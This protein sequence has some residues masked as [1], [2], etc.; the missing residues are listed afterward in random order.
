MQKITLNFNKHDPNEIDWRQRVLRKR[1][2]KTGFNEGSYHSKSAV[3]DELPKVL[4]FG[5]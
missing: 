3:E 4:R 2:R 5:D 1:D